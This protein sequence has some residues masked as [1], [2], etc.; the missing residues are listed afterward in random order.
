[1]PRFCLA[2]FIL[3]LSGC[4]SFFTAKDGTDIVSLPNGGHSVIAEEERIH[5]NAATNS[6]A[7]LDR[8][9][10][11]VWQRLRSGFQFSKR[12]RQNKRVRQK[13]DFFL[14][15][16]T[17][18]L[19][20]SSERAALYLHYIV[21]E[22]EA[23]GFPSEIA[24]LPL[25]ESGYRPEAHS[26][27]N[28]VGIWQFIASSARNYGVSIDPWYDGRRDV[29]AST[30]AALDYLS[31]LLEMFSG[32]W[33]LALAAYNSGE[34]RVLRAIEYNK[35]MNRPTDFWN[36]RLPQETKNYIPSLLA[37]A[38]IVESPEK[39]GV[40]LSAIE[41]KPFFKQVKV[42]KPVSVDSTAQLIGFPAEKL[43]LLN[44]GYKY[45]YTHPQ[46]PSRLLVPVDK[47][48]IL[49]QKIETLFAISKP[50]QFLKH[51]IVRGET[52]SGIAK[53]YG[54]TMAALKQANG[55]RGTLIRKGHS[56]VIPL[57]K[58][59]KR[60]AI[61]SQSN[62]IKKTT[63]SRS[64][65]YLVR[66]GDSLWKIGRKFNVTVSDLI[67]LNGLRKDTILKIRQRILV[68]G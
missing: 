68:D 40:K 64:Q 1:M 39:F 41:N 58:P 21:Q 34:N 35:R 13:L 49:E 62:K 4:G 50:P 23:R 14:K 28:A 26:H 47:Q 53:R 24:L 29:V 37:F 19:E 25:V 57:W 33:Y 55:I 31:A 42:A 61:A 9:A 32:D 52:L 56:L 20:R 48:S 46:K 18:Y 10:A 43:R 2:F 7:S 17:G 6:I 44:A 12:D 67:R 36:L 11:D 15:K 51:R 65:Y 5:G 60:Y 45:N 54:V 59:S 22:V 8:N 63:N 66:P 30:T 3:L 16:R 27:A 38:E